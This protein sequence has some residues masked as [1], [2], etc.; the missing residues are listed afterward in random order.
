MVD[1]CT[2]YAD[3]SVSGMSNIGGIVGRNL[4]TIKNCDNYSKNI[5]GT[6]GKVGPIAGDNSGNISQGNVDH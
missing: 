1:D 2:N 6:Y 4:G 3:A 5:T